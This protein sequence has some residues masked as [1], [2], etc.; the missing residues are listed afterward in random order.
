MSQASIV[1]KR[2]FTEARGDEMKQGEP[3][4]KRGIKADLLEDQRF[5]ELSD[6]RKLSSFSERVE[7]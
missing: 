7:K 2:S 5:P 4:N 1:S 3:S 6:L